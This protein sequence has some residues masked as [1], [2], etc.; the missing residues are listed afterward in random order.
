MRFSL[1]FA[2]FFLVLLS[3]FSCSSSQKKEVL[4]LPGK[5]VSDT[6][7]CVYKP[8]EV[9]GQE[10]KSQRGVLM[11][12]KEI[13]YDLFLREAW[14]INL[15]TDEDKLYFLKYYPLSEQIA[16]GENLLLVCKDQFPADI[17]KMIDDDPNFENNIYEVNVSGFKRSENNQFKFSRL[18][19]YY[20]GYK[21]EIT[22]M[23][24]IPNQS[25]LNPC[26]IANAPRKEY[27]ELPICRNLFVLNTKSFWINQNGTIKELSR[28][29][30]DIERKEY[31]ENIS[32]I[33]IDDFPEKYRSAALT[34]NAF[35]AIKGYKLGNNDQLSLFDDVTTKRGY[36]FEVTSVELVAPYIEPTICSFSAT[37]SRGEYLDSVEGYMYSITERLPDDGGGDKYLR[38]LM[39]INL[40]GDKAEN[41]SKYFYLT[42][43]DKLKYAEKLLF[44][45]EDKLPLDIRLKAQSKVRVSGY[46][47]GGNNAAIIYHN[48]KQN[49]GYKFEITKIEIFE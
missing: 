13:D 48:D 18:Q 14:V 49:S 20:T 5:T 23:K 37:E 9:R 6:V 3:Q 30:N 10:I 40:N 8:E 2:A 27:V 12:F 29:K 21:F 24:F 16:Y 42:D 35:F 19:W 4:P 33:C 28:L 45:C 11:Y 47:R 39:L 25:Q 22:D 1:S 15:N 43:A 7:F 31:S 44:V 34:F 36:K 26:L 32:A 41:H 46:K 17:R 38:N